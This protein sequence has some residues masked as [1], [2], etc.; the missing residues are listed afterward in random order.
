MWVLDELPP[1]SPVHVSLKVRPAEECD[2]QAGHVPLDFR[3]RAGRVEFT[4]S[5]IDI[6]AIAVVRL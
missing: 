2:L 1:V 5:R 6:N 4:V 3:S